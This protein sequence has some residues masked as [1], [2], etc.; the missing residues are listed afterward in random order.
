MATPAQDEF[1]ALVSSKDHPSSHPEDAFDDTT[2]LAPSTISMSTTTATSVKTN[3]KSLRSR[4][5]NTSKFPYRD[6]SD[7]DEEPEPQAKKNA[8]YLPKQ[9]QHDAMTGPKGVI[10]D[11]QA[12]EREKNGGRNHSFDRT[13]ELALPRA[14]WNGSQPP[15]RKSQNENAKS[16][17][18]DEEENSDDDSDEVRGWKAKRKREIEM[19]AIRRGRL[20]RE[21]GTVEVVDGMRF[22]EAIERAGRGAVVVVYIYDD[23]SN[24]SDAYLSHLVPIA[25]DHTHIQFI[26]LHC[27]EA[28]IDAAAVPAILAYRNGEKFADLM[29]LVDEVSFT[30]NVVSNL[31]EAL[32]R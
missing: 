1:D 11:A 27:E 21:Y 20:N 26:A 7:E 30:R 16:S 9:Y 24:L 13:K 2:T 15:R 6:S 4:N 18:S 3:K 12:F 28:E 29:P 32:Q 19:Q 22:L 14:Q 25:A 17:E 31:E 23:Q 8:Y 10:A 5:T